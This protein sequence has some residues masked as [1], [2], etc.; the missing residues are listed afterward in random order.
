MRVLLD[1][2]CRSNARLEGLPGERLSLSEERKEKKKEQ[3]NL[4]L[5]SYNWTNHKT[6]CPLGRRD[7]GEACRVK[8]KHSKSAQIHHTNCQASWWRGNEFGFIFQQQNMSAL[9]WLNWPWTPWRV[10]DHEE[11]NMRPP[12]WQL[13][14]GPN[15]AI[16]QYNNLKHDSKSTTWIK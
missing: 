8:T 2:D 6:P 13:K 12:V 1:T 11:S 4:D 15:W 9:H 7:Q 16:Q 14:L 10:H 5:E 3:H